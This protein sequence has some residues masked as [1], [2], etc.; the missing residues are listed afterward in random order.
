MDSVPRT[1]LGN[2]RKKALLQLNVYQAIGRLKVLCPIEI[3]FPQ[4][5]DILS[6]YRGHF[7]QN[8]T[9]KLHDASTFDMP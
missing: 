3:C 1:W 4:S 5:L 2:R 7:F 6:L 8:T 9:K